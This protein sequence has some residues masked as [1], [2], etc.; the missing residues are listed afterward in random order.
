M[1]LSRVGVIFN[2]LKVPAPIPTV[3]TTD[4]YTMTTLSAYLPEV[5]SLFTLILNFSHPQNYIVLAI[6]TLDTRQNAMTTATT[7]PSR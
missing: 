7:S 3:E 4:H 2:H 5:C 6:S 1:R